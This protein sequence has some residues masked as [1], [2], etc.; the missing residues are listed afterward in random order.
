[1][2]HDEE[3]TKKPPNQANK[4]NDAKYAQAAYQ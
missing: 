2:K 1:M 4:V 3:M